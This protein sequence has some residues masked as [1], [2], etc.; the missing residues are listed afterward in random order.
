MDYVELKSKL[1]DLLLELAG[2]DYRPMATDMAS[3]LF[4][5]IS[6]LALFYYQVY[7][8]TGDD[9]HLEQAL[10][11][12]EKSYNRLSPDNFNFSHG[13]TGI[14]WLMNYL[15]E[16]DAFSMDFE[17]YLAPYDNFVFS[18]IDKYQENIDPMHG[19]LGIANYFFTRKS[20]TATRGLLK[21]LNIVDEKKLPAGDGVTWESGKDNEDRR[22][23]RHINL[24]YGHGIPVI[25]YFMSKY[26]ERGIGPEQSRSLL[27][28]GMEYFMS[29]E[30]PGGVTSFPHRIQRGE[31]RRNARIAFCYSDLGIACGLMA[32]G[33]NL[34]DFSYLA[35]AQRIA[36]K[37]A[38]LSI[39]NSEDIDDIGLCHG[40]AGNGYMFHKLYKGLGMD[41]SGQASLVQYEQLLSLRK[42]GTGIAGFTALDF[43]NGTGRLYRRT[44]PGFI[45]GVAGMGLSIVS[46][47]Q[48]GNKSGWDKI[49]CLS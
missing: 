30:D 32:I 22:T 18:M 9:D 14:M 39:K 8:F 16:E 20:D 29:F 11:F 17:S 40:A 38:A 31:I 24:G 47:L 49:L 4:E 19:L 23:M 44:N 15:K 5:G 45:E 25:L 27:Q 10:F 3:G 1:Y 42:E 12:F 36:A 7:L 21:I 28:Q 13:S 41:I 48:D 46:F 35:I 2:H 26:I 6:G 43:D 33:K 37:I 34:G